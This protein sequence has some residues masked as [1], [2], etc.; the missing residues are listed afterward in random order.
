[1]PLCKHLMTASAFGNTEQIK[2]GKSQTQLYFI[3]IGEISVSGE[4]KSDINIGIKHGFLCINIR[5]VPRKMLET[6]L[7]RCYCIKNTEKH[8]LHFSLSLALF[9]FAFSPMSREH[10]FYGLCSF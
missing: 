4:S 8:F 6:M 7:D 3:V 9:C 2:F 5:Q 1:M 10:D